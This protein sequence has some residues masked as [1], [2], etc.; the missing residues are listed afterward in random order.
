MTRPPSGLPVPLGGSIT[1]PGG[2]RYGFLGVDG[3][4]VELRCQTPDGQ[5]WTVH[6]TVGVAVNSGGRN[7]LVSGVL[8]EEGRRPWIMLGSA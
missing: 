4:V 6:A 5:T 8:E 3:D 1:D 7:I 2:V